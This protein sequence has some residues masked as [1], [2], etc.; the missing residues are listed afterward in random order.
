MVMRYVHLAP[1]YLSDE[2][3]KLDTFS[4]ERRTN[5]KGKKRATCS[6]APSEPG[7]SG[8]IFEEKWLLR[9]DSNQQPSG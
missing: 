4:L 8:E 9:L 1:G 3:K 5:G 2:V 6:R 7:E